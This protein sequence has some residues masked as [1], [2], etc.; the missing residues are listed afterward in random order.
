[1]GDVEFTNKLN[2]KLAMHFLLIFQA[3]LK[4]TVP[5]FF[6]QYRGKEFL[7]R[8][9]FHYIFP[10]SWKR[11]FTG[12]LETYIYYFTCDISTEF[13]AITS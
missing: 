10:I 2:E 1:M 7:V 9:F 12:L 8:T 5:D 11:P 3:V 13:H 4:N 6:L